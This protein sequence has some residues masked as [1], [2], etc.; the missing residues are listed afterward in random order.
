MSN[1]VFPITALLIAISISAAP[2]SAKRKP[3]E[4]VKCDTNMGTI[5]LVDGDAAGWAKWGL[6]SPRALVNALAVE[7]GCFTPHNTADT[8][9]AR[10]LV[11][12]IA[13]DQE[14]VDR[15]I[16]L[17][18][19]GASEA[20]LRSGAAGSVVTKV[21]FGGA[22]MGAFGGFGGKKK[23]VAA[24]LRVVSPANGMTVATGSGSVRKTSLSF[25]R[26]SGGWAK[27]AAGAAGYAGSKDG[28]MLTEAFILA[29]NQL[30]VQKE[31]LSGAPASGA[32]AAASGVSVAVDTIMRAGP[33]AGSAKVRSLRAGTELTQTGQRDGL[34]I[35]VT[36][37]YGTKGW[38]SV[39]A[40][41]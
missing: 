33:E 3:P 11:T 40:L 17:A 29:F 19:T 32:A 14:E 5:A 9:P 22:L 26:N 20:L 7:S 38:V 16:S 21:P 23:T 12:A 13:G 15:G 34:F 31:V 39:E 2:A 1:R 37:N 10:F 36:D 25:G 8:A 30:A 18:K 24:G 27:S 4:L 41:N 28:R 35:E 6:G